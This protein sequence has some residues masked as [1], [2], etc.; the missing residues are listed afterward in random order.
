LVMV[1]KLVRVPAFSIL[2]ELV[3]VP[4]SKLVIMPML[5]PIFLVILV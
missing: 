5:S 3:R 2:A 1:P 4:P